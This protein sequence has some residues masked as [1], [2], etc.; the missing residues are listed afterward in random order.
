MNF[1]IKK[2]K[3]YNIL[4]FVCIFIVLSAA[5]LIRP[6]NNLD[7]LW[8]Y[9]NAINI[10]KGKLPY[11]DFN[12][13]SAPLLP[14]ISG[15]ILKLFSNELIVMRIIAIILNT[16]IIFLVYKIFKILK[17]KKSI[18]FLSLIWIYQ[19]YFDYFCIDYNFAV[20]CIALLNLYI[21]LKNLNTSDNIFNVKNQL[22]IGVLV[23]ASILLKQ[24][25]GL[26]LSVIFI[27]YKLLIVRRKEQL[28]IVSKIII[29]RMIGVLIP[30][31]LLIIYLIANNI[32]L[33]F[34]DYAIYGIKTFNNKISY[35][36]L[37]KNSEIQ[38]KLLSIIVPIT[39]IYCF[40]IS[41]KQEL[42]TIQQKNIYILSA[43]SIGCFIVVYPISDTIHFLIGSMPAII[44]LIYIFFLKLKKIKI[45]EKELNLIKKYLRYF[46][47]LVVATIMI[48][49]II[50]IAKY[51]YNNNKFSNLK[52][53]S[54][55]ISTIDNQV[56]EIDEYILEQNS[57]GKKVYIL[58]ATACLYM[59]P[60]D[61]YNKNYD[62]FLKGNLGAQGEEGQIKKL[63]NEENVIVLI[64]NEKFKY[65]WQTPENV[66]RHIIE[67]W[68]KT[69]EIL[70]FD[71]YEK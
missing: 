70:I 50:L 49:A 17:I 64:L 56:N 59:I 46:S 51:I 67:N 16:T 25:T 43:Y 18:I 14:I 62:M 28:K 48:L 12:M 63:E 68:N 4:L 60:I 30:V 8:N 37:L 39:I 41:V 71:I 65:N 54:F 10:S 55:V 5:I 31:I 61:K 22:L 24:T 42:K 11:K 7:E 66:R 38:I 21:E 35:I 45:Q 1:K 32:L 36:N 19:L 57:K 34:L 27:F 6:L 13:V 52:H 26:F 58:D 23:G 53:F 40:Y 3:I 20:L 33:D 47:E 2:E 69:E 29:M 44:T 9:N 15:V